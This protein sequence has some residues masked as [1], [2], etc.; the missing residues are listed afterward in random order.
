VDLFDRFYNPN[1]WIQRRRRLARALRACAESP[2]ELV[3]G[4]LLL[5]SAFP[6]GLLLL[7]V[8]SS[9]KRDFVFFQPPRSAKGPARGSLGLFGGR[10]AGAKVPVAEKLQVP[11]LARRAIGDLLGAKRPWGHLFLDLGLDELEAAAQFHGRAECRAQAE[12]PLK[13]A[14]LAGGGDGPKGKPGDES[15]QRAAQRVRNMSTKDAIVAT[16]VQ[17]SFAFVPLVIYV[18]PALVIGRIL[19]PLPEWR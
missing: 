9:E 17:T 2:L 4:C 1:A 19:V 13:G 6:V 14:M 3:F 11:R 18:A 10:C 5:P 8:L 16:S 7:G 12:A 15:M